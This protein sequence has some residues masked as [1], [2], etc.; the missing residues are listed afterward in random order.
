VLLRL[1]NDVG[2]L[3]TRRGDS[4]AAAYAVGCFDSIAEMEAEADRYRGF[5][6]LA[7]TKDYWLLAQGPLVRGEGDG[8]FR[9]VPQGQWPAPKALRLLAHGHGEATVN[10]QRLRIDGEQAFDVPRL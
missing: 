3:P 6:S 9:I 1:H 2:G 5:N 4:F 8:R 7:A 10:G